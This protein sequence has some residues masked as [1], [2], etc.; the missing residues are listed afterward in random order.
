MS[1][2]ADLLHRFGLPAAFALVGF[3]YIGKYVSLNPP[4]IIGFM[5]LGAMVGFLIINN[6]F[7]WSAPI[8]RSE[9]S[10]SIQSHHREPVQLLLAKE[11]SIDAVEM[12]P[13]LK[14]AKIDESGYIT[15]YIKTDKTFLAIHLNAQGRS[16]TLP[17]AFIQMRDLASGQNLYLIATSRNSNLLDEMSKKWAAR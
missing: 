6:M 4:R 1:E 14:G 11:E 13:H 10:Y 12:D 2:M 3:I 7:E 16:M 5:A 17:D 9:I 8:L 15:R